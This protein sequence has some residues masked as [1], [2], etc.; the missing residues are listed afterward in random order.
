[1]ET[2]PRALSHE[3]DAH[4]V[5]RHFRTGVRAL[6]ALAL[7]ATVVC[8]FFFREVAYLA[9]IPIPFLYA[10]LAFVNYL[11]YRSRA[12]NLCSDGE[13][14]LS[15]EELEADVETVGIVTLMKVIGVLAIGAFIVAASLFDWQIVGAAA[16]ALFFLMLLIQ[17][18]FLPLY[19]SESER[20]ELDKL[21]RERN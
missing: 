13:K 10:V 18:P 12:S 6:L 19:F 8:L 16:A 3:S 2:H 4:V 17:L 15:R 9:A 14:E 5:S 1:M 21:K 20:D 7:I 11:E